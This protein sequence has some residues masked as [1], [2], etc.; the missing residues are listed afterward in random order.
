MM[1]IGV[2]DGVCR[3]M[4]TAQAGPRLIAV[5][6]LPLL[7]AGAGIAESRDLSKYPHLEVIAAQAALLGH[8][9]HTMYP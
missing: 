9:L 5:L 6:L 8:E 1:L 3:L 2:T 4:S 7:V